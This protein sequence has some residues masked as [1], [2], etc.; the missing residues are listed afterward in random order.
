MQLVVYSHKPTWLAPESPSGYATDGG[1]PFQ[2]AALADLFETLTIIVPLVSNVERKGEIFLAGANI[3]VKPVSN[4]LGQGVWRK[5]LFPWW[6]LR[7]AYVVI[8]EGLR[9]DAIH[10]PI[11]GDIG[12]IGMLLGRIFRKPL[13]VRHC[14]N[15]TDPKTIADRLWIWSMEKFA[16]GKNVMLATGGTERPPSE[17][18]SNIHWIFSTSLRACEIEINGRMKTL[19]GVEHPALIIVGRQERG[20]GTDIVIRAL[21]RLVST[22]PGIRLHVVG[23]GQAKEEFKAL[24]VELRL[25]SRVT[26]HGKVDHDCVLRLLQASHLFCFPSSSE[27][28]PK[29]VHEAMACGLPIISSSVSV[30]ATLINDECGRLLREVNDDALATAI[31]E[32]LQDE[33][34]YERMSTNALGIAREYSLERWRDTIGEHLRR[35]WGGAL[36]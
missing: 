22:F 16:G 13:F 28:F 24:A 2:M 3:V 19:K 4:P 34:Q 29:A 20:K 15:W 21:D 11:P 5:A 23:E 32:C 30:L 31:A 1:F 33:K 8:S 14:G 35:A 7:N 17:R 27:G 26:F 36:R 10:T 9:A 6:I 12:T 18:N 25:A